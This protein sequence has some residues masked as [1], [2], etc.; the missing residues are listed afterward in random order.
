MPKDEFE[1]IREHTPKYHFQNSLLE[2]IGDDAAVYAADLEYNQLLCVDTMIEDIHFKKKT[3]SPEDIGHKALA[4]NISDIAAMG[5]IPVF[6]M[7]SIAVPAT[8]S[9]KELK[10]IYKGMTDL[11]AQYQMDMIGGDTVS[12]PHNLMI[13][14]IVYGKV[15][16]D[17]QLVRRNAKP[18]D[19]VFLTNPTGRSAAGLQLLLNKG[20]LSEFN[21]TE[22]V[23]LAH[24]Q[25]PIPKVAAGRTALKL[26]AGIALNDISDGLASEAFEIA[27]ASGTAI[28]LFKNQIPV[29]EELL[30]F[31]DERYWKWILYGGEDFELIGTVNE[32]NWPKLQ[33]AMKSE[34]MLIYEI[35]RVTEGRPSVTLIDDDKKI[36]LQKE[37]YNHFKNY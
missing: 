22:K 6:Y 28:E 19:Y 27:D 3:M 14:I 32:K 36:S 34:G 20:R 7:V 11:G 12:S 8:W 13:S 15:E 18:G 10:G 9:D 29:A 1:W 37:G 2:G 23:L 25:K 30:M 26:H 4:V 33:D 17:A 16:K 24:H 21:E 5:G 35:G 31:S